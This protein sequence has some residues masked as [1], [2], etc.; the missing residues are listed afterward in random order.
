M[1]LLVTGVTGFVGSRLALAAAQRGVQVT[2]V[3]RHVDGPLAE[4]LSA[5]GVRLLA[6][7]ITDEAFVAEATR[8]ITHVCHLAA[9]W[10]EASAPADYFQR[11]NVDG[12]LR[13]ARAAAAAG[14]RVFLY[15]STIGVHARVAAQPVSE[16]SAFDVT[17]PY[18]A[19]KLEA[20]NRLCAFA[21]SA[22]GMRIAVLRPAD[23]YGPGDL[24]LLKLFRSVQKGRF[25]L[26]GP[27]QGK[28]HM[29][30]VD[31]LVAAFLAACEAPFSTGERFIIA[32]PEVVTLAE[33]LRRLES[34][35]GSRRYGFRVPRWLMSLAAATIE[36]LCRIVRVAPPLHR[37][38]LDFYRT[39]VSYDLA[40]AREVLH[41]N[42]AVGLDEGLKRTLAWYRQ[43]RLMD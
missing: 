20:E 28:R 43:Q 23:A 39:D 33:L 16:R 6:G 19:S 3:S 9:A 15:C 1:H 11:I 10:R 12:S 41:W 35:T 17:N 31:D 22:G 7:D 26:V 4:G 25:P 37:R 5:A 21:A 27:G 13:L 14:A 8:G 34:L 24:R 38:T 40:H 18:E 32:G 2:G 29:L 36:D 42:P 30:F